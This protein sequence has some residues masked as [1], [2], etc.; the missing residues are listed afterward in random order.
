VGA[1]AGK[2]HER[3]AGIDAEFGFHPSVETG[4]DKSARVTCTFPCAWELCG[5]RTIPGG[6]AKQLV[7]HQ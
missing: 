5:W 6:A 4:F 7:V 2:V 1:A 3:S